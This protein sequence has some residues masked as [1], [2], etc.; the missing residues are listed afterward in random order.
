MTDA[1]DLQL[2]LL[3]VNQYQQ[4][5]GLRPNTLLVPPDHDLAGEVRGPL[6]LKV[7]VVDSLQDIQVAF[8]L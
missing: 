3:R 2:I 6:N 8:T 1:A 7:A 5:T 4:Q